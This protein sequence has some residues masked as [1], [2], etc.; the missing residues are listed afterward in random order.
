M[1]RS[2]STR[3]A[4]RKRMATGKD[5][6]AVGCPFCLAMLTDAAKAA[7]SEMQVKDV[8]EVVAETYCVSA[9]RKYV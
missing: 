6:L 3:T 1:A 7:K 9:S 5:T 2:A 8:A 4:L